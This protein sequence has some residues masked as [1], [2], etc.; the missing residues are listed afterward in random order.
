MREASLA[1]QAS[2]ARRAGAP[3]EKM[4][5]LLRE[6]VKA[7]PDRPDLTLKPAQHEAESQPRGAAAGSVQSR[8]RAEVEIS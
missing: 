8:L 6:A 7:A 1:S 4:P 5:P 2:P 3:H